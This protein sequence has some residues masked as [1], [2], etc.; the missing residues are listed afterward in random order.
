MGVMESEGITAQQHWTN[1]A[2][3]LVRL[4]LSAKQLAQSHVTPPVGVPAALTEVGA[5]AKAPPGHLFRGTTGTG[6]LESFDTAA[7]WAGISR[8]GCAWRIAHFLI[9]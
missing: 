4:F 2:E 5:W 9:R 6:R 7:T 3:L 1:T 8:S